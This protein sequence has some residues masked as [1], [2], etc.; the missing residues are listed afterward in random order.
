MIGIPLTKEEINELLVKEK[1]CWLATVS[2]KRQ[3]HVIP[4]NFG[5]F[6]GQVHIIFVSNNSKSVRNIENNPRVCFGINV[7]WKE[8]EIRCV[9]I[10]GRARLIDDIEA[11]KQAHL[12]ILPKYL[13]SKKEAKDFLQKLIASGTLAKRTL[14]VIKP[15]K[16]SS[17]KI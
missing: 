13:S 5:F 4:I 12:K 17:W 6:H 8:G 15:E 9:L 14:V 1:I 16:T 7:G 2:P 3:P 10:H 11:L